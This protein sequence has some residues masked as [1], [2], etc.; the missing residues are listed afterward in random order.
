ML[1]EESVLAINSLVRPKKHES[2][3]QKPK[4]PRFYA[5]YLAFLNFLVTSV[6]VSALMFYQ[7]TCNSVNYHMLSFICLLFYFAMQ[8]VTSQFKHKMR[9]S[10]GAHAMMLFG[11]ALMI[12]H[13]ASFFLI[14]FVTP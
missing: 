5:V 13:V 3:S 6:Y 8:S 4:S 9:A 2:T 7:T 1:R 12:S 10:L 14:I 11:I